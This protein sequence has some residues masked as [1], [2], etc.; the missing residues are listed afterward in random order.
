MKPKRTLFGAQRLPQSVPPS[1]ASLR[2][3]T[4]R[5]RH[6]NASRPLAPVR[7]RSRSGTS[8]GF[9]GACVV[10]VC[11]EDILCPGLVIRHP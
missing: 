6:K 10:C 4:V 1:G 9:F 7:A 11:A 5:W 8:L 2:V 3:D